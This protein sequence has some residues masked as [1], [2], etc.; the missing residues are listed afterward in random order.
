MYAVIN[1]LGHI[2][3]FEHEPRN[4]GRFTDVEISP[5]LVRELRA[6]REAGFVIKYKDAEFVVEAPRH[7][8]TWEQI[9]EQRDTK[10]AEA[11]AELFRLI[12]DE[13]INAQDHTASKR[14]VAT[15]RKELRDVPQTFAQPQDV[16]WPTPPFA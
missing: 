5:D 12:D 13:L 15:Y 6:Q 3:S 2:L 14:D 16:V 11:D 10:F 8:V 4:D 1:G 9:R 7:V